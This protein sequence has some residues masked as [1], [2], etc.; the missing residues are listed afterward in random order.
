MNGWTWSEGRH[1]FAGNFRLIKTFDRRKNH[2]EQKAVGK[3]K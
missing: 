2:F 3:T 1:R